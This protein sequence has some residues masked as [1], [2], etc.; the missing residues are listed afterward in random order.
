MYNHTLSGAFCQA[1][2]SGR[3]RSAPGEDWTRTVHLV[4]IV[5]L[6]VAL[7]SLPATLL[8]KYE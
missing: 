7:F 2:V 8:K 4:V 5:G 6:P 1:A 3:R